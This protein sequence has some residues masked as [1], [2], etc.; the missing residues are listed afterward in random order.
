MLIFFP[1][2]KLIDIIIDCM[3]R[4]DSEEQLERQQ[5]SLEAQQLFEMQSEVIEKL[6]NR[7]ETLEQER[8]YYRS[9]RNM[10]AKQL[11]ELQ[12]ETDNGR[13]S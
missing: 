5:I 1:L 13:G 3:R 4:R 8:D 2:A 7:I 11:Y 10:Y 6:Q 9:E 12:Q